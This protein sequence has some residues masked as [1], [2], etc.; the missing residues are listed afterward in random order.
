MTISI[1][2]K[3]VSAI[4]DSADTTIVRPTNWNDTHA[5][6]GLGT[7]VETALGINIG[8][9]G[10]VVINGGAL[11]TPSSGNL[12]NCTGYPASAVASGAA[13]TRVSDTNVVLTLGGTPAT[14]LLV[15]TSIT[16][17]WSGTLA[18]SRGGFGADVSGSSGVPLFAA[19]AP[20][21]TGTTGTGNFARADSPA[22]TTTPTAPT[23]GA[24]TNTTQIATTAFVLA[25]A[26]S[27]IVIQKF[28]ANGTYTPTSGMKYCLVQA[29]G[30]GGGGGGGTGSAG[31]IFSANGGGAGG[32]SLA[33]LTAAQI[34]VS[35][36]VAI[37]AGG[38]GGA[39]GNNQ[40]SAGGDTTLGSTL[41]IAKGGSGGD[42]CNIVH[43]GTGGAG[44]V[45][46]TG[47]VTT[48]G[49][50]SDPAV[51]H[52][53][54]ANIAYSVFGGVTTLCGRVDATVV[55]NS[56]ANGPAAAANTG[57]GGG[58]GLSQNTTNTFAGGNGGS[59]FMVITEFI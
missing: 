28:T 19:G 55:A 20:T 16:V 46:G 59:G 6:S 14:A 31:G 21:F 56:S 39:A 3:F 47:D 41:I 33:R 32:Y 17:S 54:D 7:G 24:G 12:A 37:G 52:P 36:T 15:A 44:G 48:A 43:A 25:N 5:L 13:L 58:G 53:T 2:H 34:G 26:V 10:S 4:P 42:F 57:N 18:A 50:A 8:T 23:A 9:A 1:T 27:S 29:W 40:G 22:F 30:G 51:Y 11:G 35:K 38:N 49:N 45:A